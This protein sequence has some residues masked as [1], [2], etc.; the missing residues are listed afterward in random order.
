MS[1]RIGDGVV[2]ID[3]LLGGWEKVTA[4]YLVE[5]PEPVLGLTEH[6][7]PAI[8]AVSVAAHRVLAET[9]AVVPVGVCGLKR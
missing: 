3:T 2:E 8:L 7:Q 4:G 9:S 6:A 5:G 1:T